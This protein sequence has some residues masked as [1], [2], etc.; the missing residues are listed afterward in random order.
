[1]KPIVVIA[2]ATATGKTA[3]A[4]ELARDLGGELVGADSMQVYRGFDIGTAKPTRAE[5]GPIRHHLVDVLAPTEEIDAARYAA[6][7]DIVIEEIRFRGNLPIV[8]GGT[9]LWIRALVRGLVP[10][11]A[12]DPAIRAALEEEVA[13]EGASALHTRLQ[14][15]DPA[16]AERVHPNDALRIV[17][18]LEVFAQT[19]VP[20]GAHRAAHAL[21]TPRYNAFFV[22]LKPPIDFEAGLDARLDAMFRAGFV[23]EVRRLL[24]TVPKTARPFR[25][26]G[27]RQIVEWLDAPTG[28]D[29]LR[30]LVR[31]A[32]RIYARRQRTWFASEPGVTLRASREEVW[33]A[34]AHLRSFLSWGQTNP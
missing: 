33:D 15:L 14:T 22:V 27:Y 9:G 20:I 2:G 32:T 24:G 30:R 26:V 10:L 7:A 16:T 25:S 5:L 18:A 17:R 31:K 3:L 1:V 29:D 28:E 13:R 34:R 21:G 8:V 4:I 12:P 6:M 19:G 23:E 11:P